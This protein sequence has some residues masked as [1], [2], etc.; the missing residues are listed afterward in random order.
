MNSSLKMLQRRISVNNF[1]KN[2]FKNFPVLLRDV[3]NND[4]KKYTQQG[5]EE[6]SDE[7]KE[8]INT[9]QKRHKILNLKVICVLSCEIMLGE[10]IVDVDDYVYVSNND[11]PEMHNDN[12]LIYSECHNKTWKIH[13][14]GLIEIIEKGDMIERI[15]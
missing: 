6:L 8:I 9:L 14:T 4:V 10:S 3:E 5:I 2:I 11:K 12:L 7:N 13:E 15:F 1:N